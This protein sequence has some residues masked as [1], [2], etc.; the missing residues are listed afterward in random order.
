MKKYINIFVCI[1][2]FFSSC[3]SDFID[4][5]PIAT[6]TQNRYYQTDKDFADALTGIYVPLRARYNNFYIFADLRAD[7]S[8][9]QIAKADDQTY[10]DQFTMNSNNGQL[11][12]AW[13]DYYQ[14]IFR[15]NNLLIK[16][17]P[18]NESDVPN[19]N[20][21]V[22][23][24]RFLRALCYFDL[25][26]IFGPVPAV[27]TVLSVSEAY[28]T[29]R[30][31][32]DDIYN[33]I[34]E[35][36]RA[37]E[38]LPAS[39]TGDDI[40]RPTSGAA[41]ALL[42]RVY[43]TKGDFVN[44]ENK[45]LEVTNMGYTLVDDFESIFNPANK[46]HKE[47]I[48]DYEYES[49]VNAG[50]SLTNLM[51]PNSAAFQAFYGVLGTG[52]ERNGPTQALIDLFEP[53]DLRKD[54]SIG[55]Y[56]G[57]IDATGEFVAL[58]STTNQTYTKKYLTRIQA[59]NDSP[60]NW[61]IIRYA[62]V[63]LMLAE[64]MNENGKTAQAIPFVNDVRRRAGVDEYPT[65]MNQS[66]ARAAIDKERRLELCFEGVRWF[67]IVRT[68]QAYEIMKDF[69]MAPY[70]TVFPIPLNQVQLVNDPSIMPQ[71]AGYN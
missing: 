65:T 11:S 43:L 25:V 36:L 20:R 32:V 66:D 47:Y 28:Q 15:A 56:G 51:S 23:E 24:A 1:S 52:N 21:Y 22:A 19:K 48:F 14:S 39:Y 67:D 64:S 9:Q 8:W 16:I 62:D 57:F 49:G 54:I 55:I 71:N 69:G 40:G 4:I 58:P 29:P 70:M 63:L 61:R 46:H 37:A 60:V 38:I 59:A 2:L 3:S 34:I 35:D 50:S 44:A 12:S 41:K 42:G 10:S 6:V 45:L 53:H 5:L 18:L 13:T 7:D 68:G 33:I 27:T 17:D 30:A 31:P 26:R